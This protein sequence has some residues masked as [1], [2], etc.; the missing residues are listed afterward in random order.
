MNGGNVGGGG[1]GAPLSRDLSRSPA[2]RELAA[3]RELAARESASREKD[4]RAPERSI[5]GPTKPGI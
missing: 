2:T 4:H 5:V 3:A 1:G